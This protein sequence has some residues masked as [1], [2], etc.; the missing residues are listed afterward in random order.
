MHN[1]WL[2]AGLFLNSACI[3]IRRYFQIMPDWL[4]LSCLIL[5]IAL[6]LIGIFKSR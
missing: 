2:A 6:M 4:Y 3:L 1:Y 5:G